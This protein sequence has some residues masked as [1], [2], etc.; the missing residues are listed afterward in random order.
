MCRGWTPIPSGTGGAFRRGTGPVVPPP[1][2]GPSGGKGG[3]LGGVEPRPLFI[4]VDGEKAVVAP[5]PLKMRSGRARRRRTGSVTEIVAVPSSG[6]SREVRLRFAAQ[7]GLVLLFLSGILNAAGLPWWAVIG[8]S[9]LILAS[10]TIEQARAARPG[11]IAIPA[12]DQHHV[13]ITAQE[14]AAYE[15]ALVVAR[16]IRGTWPAL[17]HMIDPVD[18]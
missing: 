15:K 5:Y 16:R 11:R 9:A 13:L 2:S 17:A 18:A 3:V 6:R 4:G 12:G 10:V 14:R 7:L 8:G 1:R